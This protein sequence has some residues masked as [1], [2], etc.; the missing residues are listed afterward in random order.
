MNQY[1]NYLFEA[2]MKFE[3]SVEIRIRQSKHH[4]LFT[5]STSDNL[6][7]GTNTISFQHEITGFSP[8]E[9]DVLMHPIIEE[10]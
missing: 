8:D 6:R 1:L 7:K 4:M 10:V 2:L 3:L 9:H 5:Q